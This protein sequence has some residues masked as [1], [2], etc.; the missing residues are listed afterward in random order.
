MTSHR[1]LSVAGA[2]SYNYLIYPMTD[3]LADSDPLAESVDKGELAQ[4]VIRTGDADLVAQLLTAA[5]PK[6]NVEVFGPPL[7]PPASHS[8]KHNASSIVDLTCDRTSLERPSRYDVV[9]IRQIGKRPV[10][11]APPADKITSTTA[12]TAII[13][14]SGEAFQDVEPALDFL[15]KLKPKYIIHHTTRPL[16]TG[17]LWDILRNGPM[18]RDGVPDPDHLAVI[19]D[20][21]DLRAEGIPLSR[22]LS[23]EATAEDFVRNLGSNGRLDTLVTCPNLIVRF[24]NEGIIHHRGRDAVGPQ[25]YFRPGHMEQS[26]MQMSGT[27]SAFTAGF[28][29]GFPDT[30][31]GIRLGL[32]A[33]N[34][35]SRSGFTLNKDDEAPDY[36]VNSIMENLSEKERA[37]TVKVPSADISS[38]GSF[39][40]FDALTG[41]PSEVAREIVTKGHD[42]ALAHCSVQKF[43]KLFTA[44]RREQ[45]SLGSIVETVDERFGSKTAAPTCIGVFG[46]IGS[47]KK[48]LASSLS[49]AVS[50]EWPL[51]RLTYDTQVMRAEDLSVICNT[52]RDHS[53]EGYISVVSFENFE[54]LLEEK[55]PLFD[56]VSSL[57][58]RGTFKDGT[59][60]HK[61]GR[62]LLLFLVKQEPPRSE[63]TPTPTQVHFDLDRTD[64]STSL[65]NLHGVVRLL[66]P[67]QSGPQD[68]LF[69]VRRAFMLRQLLFERHPPL[70][71]N[72]TIKIDETVLRALL[73]V[74]AYKKGLRSLERI[75]STS[76]LSGRAKFDIAALP[77]EDQI[78]EEVPEV[79]TFMAFL[80]SP[81]L[82]PV[83][84]ERI[85][86]GI[87]ERYKQQRRIMSVTPEQQK[88]L[89]N[90]RAMVDWDE[91]SSELKE[92]TRAQADDI[93]RKLRAVGY[94]MLEGEKDSDA[95][96]HVPEFTKEDLD[97]LDKMEH[98]RF[99]AE[100]LQKQW[101]AGKR[102][103][104]Q[105]TTPFLV[106]WKDL[107]EE[108]QLVDRVMVECVPGILEKTGYRI[109]KMKK[110]E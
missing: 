7:Q 23:W 13:T 78:A 77:P 47:G 42:R 97:I 89:L 1:V 8:L 93:P 60:E 80:R 104:K 14:G 86:E 58:R 88:E 79:R 3:C 49:D 61:I 65:D 87:F 66:G 71:V 18:T 105:R 62:C 26:H 76:R 30:D 25:L 31:L 40:I 103:A 43:G 39:S 17:R 2:V 29:L 56:Q 28:A 12:G 52:V 57:M 16:A 92:S 102:N 15:Q 37:S 53:E 19:L 70:E 41:D 74:P 32:T 94:F 98:E 51:K 91:L 45:E 27:A 4:L 36:D 64:T 21:E 59:H 54:H 55:G 24:G 38:G 9:N 95:M 99:N 34:R 48:F 35:L 106:P 96:V 73:F 83:L 84:R 11:H 109:Y 44:D 50:S 110:M 108:W 63:S 101:R 100:R 5:A 85:A 69:A 81:K 90:D 46:P 68:K 107:T 6:W 82:P 72:G 33:S 20:A 22:G 67:N 10:W 75:I